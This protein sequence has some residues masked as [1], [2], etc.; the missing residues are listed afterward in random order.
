MPNVT[1]ATLTGTGDLYLSV[2]AATYLPTSVLDFGSGAHNLDMTHIGT[3]NNPCLVLLVATY[4]SPYSVPS[5]TFNGYSM[6]VSPVAHGSGGQP[7][8]SRFMAVLPITPGMTFAD[9]KFYVAYP[10]TASVFACA[11]ELTCFYNVDGTSTL[12]ALSSAPTLVHVFNGVNPDGFTLPSALAL[13]TGDA[14]LSYCGSYDWG[15]LSNYP[16]VSA[17]SGFSV[18]S[19]VSLGASGLFTSMAW[20]V[21]PSAESDTITWSVNQAASGVYMALGAIRLV[22]TPS[23]ATIPDVTGEPLATAEANL[24]SAGFVTGVVSGATS[25]TVPIGDVISQN[26]AG[27]TVAA[28]G[29]AVDLVESVSAVVPNVFNLS[30]AAATA[31]ILAAGLTLGTV[32]TQSDVLI[33]PGNVD[34][35]SPAAGTIVSAGSAVN[36][37][38]SS[39]RAG[40]V[41]PNVVGLTPTQANTLLNSQGFVVNAVA[42]AAS[43]TVPAGIILS[44]N[45]SAG[46]PTSYGSFVGYTVSLGAPQALGA[47]DFNATVISQYAN[48]PTILRLV[49]NMAQYVDQSQNFAN[50]YS[51]VWNV[52][53]AQGFGLDIWG[54]IVGVSRLLQIPNSDAFVG[55]QD[56]SHSGPGVGWD[57]QPFDASGTFYGGGT[58]TQS[59]LLDDPSYRVLILAKAL[60]NISSTSVP[61]FN[62]LL[63][64]LFGAGQAYVT[65]PGTMSFVITLNFVPSAIQLA[66]LQNSGVIPRPAGVSFTV[67]HP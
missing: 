58:A 41:V 19:N 35:Q 25:G 46:S 1:Q 37:T 14:A 15:G 59:Y 4:P 56:G 27:G 64:N 66:I 8:R 26:P 53:T 7:E 50:F 54:R 34:A 47:F 31:A 33:I 24:V 51:F 21:A 61:A 9:A 40:L 20:R 28:L 44:Q 32:G 22:A 16:Y 3:A 42:Y 43:D 6:T 63:Q 29:T 36:I 2:D 45:P 12:A 17:P 10:G 38:L 23:T 39:G 60:S 57:V 48:S 5:V 65:D 18:L 62:Q 55:F 67:S 11:G 49:S 52:D 30:E 13:N